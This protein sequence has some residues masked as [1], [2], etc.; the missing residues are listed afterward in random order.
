MLVAQME[1][2]FAE[3]RLE[4]LEGGEV[5]VR[6]FAPVQAE[7]DYTCR[8]QIV[9]PDREREFRGHGIDGLQ[10]LLLAIQMARADLLHSPEGTA[11]KLRWLGGP[12]LGLPTV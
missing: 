4:L 6:F 8:Y 5:L 11:G 10:A 1:V 9:W 3:R 12:D 2:S 7:V